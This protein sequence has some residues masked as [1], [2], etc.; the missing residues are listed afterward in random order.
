MFLRAE[1]SED[2]ILQV[3]EKNIKFE[4]HGGRLQF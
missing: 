1:L 4:L 2:I 3:N